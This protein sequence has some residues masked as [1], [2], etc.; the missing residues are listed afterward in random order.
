MNAQ[1]SIAI[2]RP[3]RK[4]VKGAAAKAIAKPSTDSASAL[5]PSSESSAQREARIRTR[6]YE[7]YEQHGFQDGHDLDNWLQ[8]ERELLASQSVATQ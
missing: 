3:V 4:F 2:P 7:L 8:A 6:A 1:P 5:S